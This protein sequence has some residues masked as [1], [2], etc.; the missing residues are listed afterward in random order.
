M[1]H[2]VTVSMVIAAICVVIWEFYPE[3]MTRVGWIIFGVAAGYGLL[4]AFLPERILKRRISHRE[5]LPF[6]DIYRA[7]FQQLPYSRNLIE[8]AWNE[9]ASDLALDARKL[10]P[11]DRFE[12]ELS[13]KGFPLD[14]LS[15]TASARLMKRLQAV[16]ASS[17][18]AK[19]TSSIK[20]VRDYIEFICAI[21]C[22]RAP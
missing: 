7:N 13:V 3:K 15:E 8:N 10:R 19:K 17:S 18:D 5:A 20:T 9:L 16:K 1:K 21:E 14:D 2:L 22:K 12:V 11:A 4:S 6:D